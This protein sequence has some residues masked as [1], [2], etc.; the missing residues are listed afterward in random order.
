[1]SGKRN[2]NITE[3]I[4]I[5]TLFSIAMGF[6][7]SAVV[8]YLRRIYY[9][10]GFNFPLQP[11]DGPIAL[12][13]ILREVATMIM[14]ITIAMLTGRT[15][16]ERFGF[17]IFAFG[18]WDIFYYVFLYILLGWPQSLFTWDILFLIPTT[19]VGPVLGPVINS[20]SMI[21]LALLISKFTN[22]NRQVHIKSNEWILLISGSLVVIISYV[23]DYIGYLRGNFT[24]WEIF[25]PGRVDELMEYALDYIPVDFSWWIFI[26]GQLMITA[27]IV[28]FYR[29][30]SVRVK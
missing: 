5:L 18:I 28:L 26:V 12:T 4:L 25:H 2:I 14:L 27:G 17:F 13:E 15:K 29:R 10:D 7:E 3:F 8:V 22:H 6:M 20:L 24:F 21:A 23:E 9:P 1:M 30:N 19:W 16:T 11:I